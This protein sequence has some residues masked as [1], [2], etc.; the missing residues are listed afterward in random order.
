M[1]KAKSYLVKVNNVSKQYGSDTVIEDISFEINK[2]E[3]LA[4]IGPNGSGKSTLIKIIVGLIEANAGS[5]DFNFASKNRQWTI[6]YVPQSFHVGKQL[7]LTVEEFLHLTACRAAKHNTK[8]SIKEA[9]KAVETPELVGKQLSQLSG[10]QLQRVLIARSILHET[11]LLVLDEPVT[12]IDV[13]G[14]LAIYKL[15]KK[16]QKDRG[17]TSIVV[18]HELD[19]VGKYATS[20][21]CLNKRLICHT[22][23][24]KALANE[25]LKS[26]YGSHVHA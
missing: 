19:F 12:G 23:P 9:L 22:T 25:S 10:G 21:V 2:G 15:L 16:L 11:E 18:S 13:K 3:L 8:S 14:E 6:G 26:L 20:V 17:T 7:P 24:A 5:V 4:I 1:P